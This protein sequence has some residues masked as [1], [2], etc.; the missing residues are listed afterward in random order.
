MK[1]LD[2]PLSDNHRCFL[3]DK[4]EQRARN[5]SSLVIADCHF[6]VTSRCGDTHGKGDAAQVAV[7]V[8]SDDEVVVIARRL[9]HW[10]CY[11][12]GEVDLFAR[13]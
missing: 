12:D 4:C 7:V 3:L 13:R 1:C 11:L 5:Q 9:V 8:G 6:K 10:G 2:H